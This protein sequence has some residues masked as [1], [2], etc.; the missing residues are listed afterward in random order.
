[1]LRSTEGPIPIIFLRLLSNS[2]LFQHGGGG[3]VTPA[4]SAVNHSPSCW[5]TGADRLGRE[6]RW[7]AKLCSGQT[8]RLP[9]IPIGSITGGVVSGFSHVGIVPDDA[10]GRRVTSRFSRFPRHFIPALFHTH[11][12]HRRRLS[13]PR[14]EEPPKSLHSNKGC[15]TRVNRGHAFFR[16]AMMTRA[17]LE[18]SG[19]AHHTRTVLPSDRPEQSWPER[20]NWRVCGGLQVNRRDC[21]PVGIPSVPPAGQR[22]HRQNGPVRRFFVPEF[23]DAFRGL[24]CLWKVKCKSYHSREIKDT[25][26]APL[27]EKVKTIIPMQLGT[28]FEKKKKHNFRSNFRKEHK[29]VQ[30]CKKSGMSTQDTYVPKLWYYQDL[31]F[32]VDPEEAFQKRIFIECLVL[33]ASGKGWQRFT[34]STSNTVE[35]GMPIWCAIEHVLVEGT[36]LM[37]WRI[38]SSSRTASTDRGRPALRMPHGSVSPGCVVRCSGQLDQLIRRRPE[39]AEYCGHGPQRRNFSKAWIALIRG[40]LDH[41]T[42]QT[43]AS[44]LRLQL[45]PITRHSRGTITRGHTAHSFRVLADRAHFSAAVTPLV[46]LA[47]SSL[48]TGRL[49]TGSYIRLASPTATT[50]HTTRSTT[51]PCDDPLVTLG[52]RGLIIGWVAPRFSHVGIVPDD[53]TGQWFFSTISRILRPCISVL[54]HIHFTSPISTQKNSLLRAVEISP[55][56][57]CALAYIAYTKDTALARCPLSARATHLPG[58]GDRASHQG[59]LGSILAGSPNFR[60][61]ESCQTIPLVGG[62]FFGDLPFPLPFQSGVA[63]YSPQ[64]PSSALNTS[65]LRTAQISSLTHSLTNSFSTEL[66]D[67]V[68]TAMVDAL[69]QLSY[70]DMSWSKGFKISDR[71]ECVSAGDE[72]IFCWILLSVLERGEGG[73]VGKATTLS[74]TD[75]ARFFPHRP[76]HYIQAEEDGSDGACGMALTSGSRDPSDLAKLKLA[77]LGEVADVSRGMAFASVVGGDGCG[78][79]FASNNSSGKMAKLILATL[80]DGR[81]F[82]L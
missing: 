41:H 4:R 64:S 9:P 30:Q 50:G 39:R 38:T 3:S 82:A 17:K 56:H 61:W 34:H 59:E 80:E 1:M 23:I 67:L 62:F 68:V 25:M 40:T 31:L 22:A 74:A 32:L 43:S 18:E 5:P 46:K 71:L 66:S 37:C 21:W 65:L 47:L 16:S 60:T 15:N 28:L 2:Q 11:L 53:A 57:F 77:T 44:L 6:K 27:L 19:K 14:C 49:H 35:W 69:S 12:N 52:E 29:K 75:I 78:M 76:C 7:S 55:L 81:L 24:P 26:Y 72:R 58:H 10:T 54:L 13:R 36:S 63:T 42:N 45:S 51:N 8:T 20:Q 79:A 48:D 33:S 70:R 73:I